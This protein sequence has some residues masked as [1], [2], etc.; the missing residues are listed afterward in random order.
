MHPL[1]QPACCL[2]IPIN[3][4]RSKKDVH[5]KL[6]CSLCFVVRGASSSCCQCRLLA[7]R[8]KACIHKKRLEEV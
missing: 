2:R 5:V 4:R 8:K 1:L 6:E 3:D 7:L